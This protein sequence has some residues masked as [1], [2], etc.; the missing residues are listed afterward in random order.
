MSYPAKTY[1]WSAV[2]NN[3]NDGTCHSC[4]VPGFDYRAVCKAK[5]FINVRDL[6][7]LARDPPYQDYAFF[8][9]KGIPQMTSGGPIGIGIHTDIESS[10]RQNMSRDPDGC[11]TYEFRDYGAPVPMPYLW[12]QPD[13]RPL[14]FTDSTRQF[15]KDRIR[16]EVLAPGQKTYSYEGPNGVE[17]YEDV[18]AYECEEPWNFVTKYVNV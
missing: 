7:N 2:C 5:G 6:G 17:S 1:P 16:A 15:V 4:H 14:H 8:R 11:H 13:Y 3:D 12:Q 18:S 10:L 9:S